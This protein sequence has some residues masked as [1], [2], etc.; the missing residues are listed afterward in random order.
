MSRATLIVTLALVITWLFVVPSNAQDAETSAP[1]PLPTKEQAG[2]D[3]KAIVELYTKHKEAFRGI[4]G[5]V[6]VHETSAEGMLKLCET[7]LARLQELQATAIPEIEPVLGRVTELWAEPGAEAEARA[8]EGFDVAEFAFQQSSDIEWNMKMAA[9]D[10]DVRAARDLPEE[11]DSVGSRYS[12][13]VR[14]VSSVDRTRRANAVYLANYVKDQPEITFFVQDKR[15]DIMN[16]W[17]TCLEW[18]LR[19]DAT[20]EYANQRMATIATEIADMQKALEAEIDEKEWKGHVEDFAGPGSVSELAAA[21]KEYFRKDR[22]WGKQ[23]DDVPEED[24]GKGVEVLAV[25][26]RGPWQVAETDIFGRVT[27]WRLPIHLAVTKPADRARN[28]ARV[29]ELSA[30]A[31]VGAPGQARKAPPFD[32]FWVGN[33]WMMRLN[34]MPGG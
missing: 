21:A 2:V 18:S 19:F 25:A 6:T 33:S 32:G 27:C 9:A 22:D 24:R 26:V 17:K 31:Q 15:L 14:M 4:E 34:K 8:Q 7:E 1:A 13:L 28:I 30:C 5:G 29:Y 10:N 23:G 11:F 12:D 16:Q 3:A 20:N